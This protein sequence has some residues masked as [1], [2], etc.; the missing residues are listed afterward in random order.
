[1]RKIDQSKKAKAEFWSPLTDFIK[2]NRTRKECA[3]YMQSS[4][5]VI[6]EEIRQISLHYP[7]ISHSGKK[8]YRLAKSIDSLNVTELESEILEV[9]KTIF[10]LYSRI[11]FLK[12]RLKPLIAYKKMAEKI[13]EERLNAISPDPEPAA[14]QEQNKQAS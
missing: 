3:E 2:E 8:G 5:G 6:R 1:M 13:L 10:D 11:K 7:V 12:R 14:D 9:N 4:D